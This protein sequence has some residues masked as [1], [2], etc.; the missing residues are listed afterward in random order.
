MNTWIWSLE[1]DLLW[2]FSGISAPSA[3]CYG[4]NVASKRPCP[5][6]SSPCTPGGTRNTA[7]PVVLQVGLGGVRTVMTR[8][9]W[10]IPHRS[11]TGSSGV[12][13]RTA[14]CEDQ[15]GDLWRGRPPEQGVTIH[16]WT[17]HR[18]GS[19][20]TSSHPAWGA[21]EI[22]SSG[23]PWSSRVRGSLVFGRGSKRA[24]RESRTSLHLPGPL[25]GDFP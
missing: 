17:A 24:Q 3:G 15:R 21:D 1:G 2:S 4:I 6:K 8:A 7:E 23:A 11:R 9:L 22:D 16:A 20:S 13:A 25:D 19:I 12:S 10:C 18:S 5:T 14:I